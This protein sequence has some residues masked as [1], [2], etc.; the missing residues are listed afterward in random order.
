MNIGE[1]ILREGSRGADVVVLQSL[2]NTRM[3]PTP[4]LKIDGVF[5]AAT[6]R[7][8]ELFQLRSGLVVD[9]MVGPRTREALRGAPA[10]QV[11][12]EELANPKYSNGTAWLR[13]A[14]GEQ[15]AKVKEIA[16]KDHHRRIIEYHA[17]TTLRA[18]T[19]EVPWCS[20]FVNW[21]LKEA[22]LKGTNSA[23]AASWLN[24]GLPLKEPRTGAITVI[25]HIGRSD[26]STGSS[27]GNHVG[28]LIGHSK[29]GV[30]L[31]GGNQGNQVKES[32]YSFK[33]FQ[34]RGMR[35]PA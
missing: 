3:M 17:T 29:D 9:G 2:L 24:W 35:W 1:R 32:F 5:G 22:G 31:L 33:K 18:T 27:T 4:P 28:F 34:L 6:R 8:V 25:K 26:A 21:C 10:K 30:R 20:S 11:T 16:G 7:Q 15:A 14:Y 23:A 19:D 13:I 12:K